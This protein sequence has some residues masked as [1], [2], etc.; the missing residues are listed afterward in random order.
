MAS[1]PTSQGLA[2]A[3]RCRQGL[4]VDEKTIGQVV[5]NIKREARTDAAAAAA[6]LIDCAVELSNKLPL[7]ALLIG[8]CLA[9]AS[10]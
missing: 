3:F 4:D 2:S 6:M 9:A 7:Y 1:Q 5:T 10:W 8:R